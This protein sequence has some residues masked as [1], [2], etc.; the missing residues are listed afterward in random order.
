MGHNYI[1]DK[2]GNPVVEPD[3]LKWARW[4]ETSGMKRVVKKTSVEGYEV[5]TVFLGTDYS[6]S[7]KDEPTLYETMVFNKEPVTEEIMG[8]KLT[9]RKS[10]DL[11]GLFNRYHT[12]DESEAGH[13]EIATEL[14]RK[15]S[16]KE[17]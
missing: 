16:E 7:E 17:L 13:E 2:K 4:F 6:F 3:V 10:V 5:S 12:R 14:K 15:I 11:D 8:K 9:F 1:L